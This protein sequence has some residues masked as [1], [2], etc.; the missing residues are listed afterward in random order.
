MKPA[1]HP[2]TETT[3]VPELKCGPFRPNDSGPLAMLRSARSAEFS[4]NMSNNVDRR[5]SDDI[6]ILSI[7]G[8]LEHHAGW[9]WESFEAI[10]HR[11][12]KVL[13]GD[14]VVQAAVE[15][16]R[17][18]AWAENRA[19][20]P[21]SAKPRPARAVILRID[22]PGGEAAGSM[23]THRAIR[24]LR[25]RHGI[26][27]Y[28]YADELAASA[29]Y[30]IAS[31]CDEIWLPDTGMVGSIG[32]IA[33]LFDRTQQNYNA[34]LAIEL[35]TS[36]KYKADSHADRRITD[37]I[38]ARMQR[39]VD[40]LADIFFETVAKARGGSAKAVADLEAALFAGDKAVAAGLADG[41]ADFP[42]FMRIVRRSLAATTT[43]VAA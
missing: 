39:R 13:V 14:D 23:S 30:A 43:S 3:D 36:G 19:P 9:C 4:Y 22:S 27:V 7:Q 10:L 21:V 20:D 34:G 15:A 6:A 35:V 31:A 2:P 16:E 18:R 25:K 12:E 32:V 41:V 42:K 33:T 24:R 5:T 8:P 38:R 11:L 1:P 40:D 29:A 37:G 26:P 28:A 17:Q